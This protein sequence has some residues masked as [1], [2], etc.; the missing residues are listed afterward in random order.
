MAE[1]KTK[2]IIRHFRWLYHSLKF[3]LWWERFG[4]YLGAFPNP[5]DLDYLEAVWRGER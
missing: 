5:N 3:W 2:P 1:L 4:R